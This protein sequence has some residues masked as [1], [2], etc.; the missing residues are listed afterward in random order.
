MVIEAAQQTAKSLQFD[1]LQTPREKN[2]L[3]GPSKQQRHKKNRVTPAESRHRV[4]PESKNRVTPDNKGGVT[5]D[6]KLR[7]TPDITYRASPECKITPRPATVPEQ[8]TR[9]VTSG[10]ETTVRGS[11]HHI[12]KAAIAQH[13]S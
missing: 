5:P 8:A 7:V 13:S 6:S 1:K 2:D 9:P 10:A 11:Y 12:L 4:T 3:P